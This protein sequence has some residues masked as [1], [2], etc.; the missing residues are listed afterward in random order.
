MYTYTYTRTSVTKG[1]VPQ[2]GKTTHV[3]WMYCSTHTH[4]S[5]AKSSTALH[6]KCLFMLAACLYLRISRAAYML[7]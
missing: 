5:D 3:E 4:T 1:I 6:T 2:P 7:S